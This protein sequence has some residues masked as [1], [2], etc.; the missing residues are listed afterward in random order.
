L[1]GR[2]LAVCAGLLI[3][4]SATRFNFADNES[5]AREL[6]VKARAAFVI[7]GPSPAASVEKRPAAFEFEKGIPQQVEI[8]D[9]LPRTARRLAAKPG[10]RH[11]IKNALRFPLE[12]RHKEAPYAFSASVNFPGKMA[13]STSAV[14]SDPI[15]APLPAAVTRKS[16]RRLRYYAYSFWRS[17]QPETDQIA[18]AAQ[19]G[20]SQSGV[21]ANYRLTNRDGRNLSLI[22]RAAAMPGKFANEEL[23]VGLRWQPFNS[24]PLNVTA[25]RRIRTNSADQFALYGAGSADDIPLALGFRGRGFAQAGIIPA[26]QLNIFFDAG[27]RSETTIIETGQNAVSMGIGGWA[28]GQ[29]GASRFDIGPTIRGDIGIGRTRL[30]VSA[31]WRFRVG[32]NAR[33]G[34]GPAV[35][36]S[37]GF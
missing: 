9:F 36:I 16:N 25:E 19:Y 12:S 35:T 33:P 2:P 34:H 32:G 18:P 26:R 8:Y 24:L 6:P 1:R 20:G 30:D 13:G 23:A 27:A 28:G 21:I 10:H 14:L 7:A 37:T 17:G 22:V 4:W 11:A 5:S 31:D 3:L 29:R 15:L